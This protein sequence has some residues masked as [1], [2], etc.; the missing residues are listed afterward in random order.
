MASPIENPQTAGPGE[1]RV[2]EEEAEDLS[3]SSKADGEHPDHST[4]KVRS[5]HQQYYVHIILSQ[6][7]IS[8]PA[9]LSTNY[10]SQELNSILITA[11][12][13]TA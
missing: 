2:E 5:S 13:F 12:T 3:G 4:T 7:H 9:R 11:H 1:E 10:I 6:S 8:I